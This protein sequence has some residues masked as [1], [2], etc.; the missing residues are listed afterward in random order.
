MIAAQSQRA[1]IGVARA[2]LLAA[3][4]GAAGAGAQTLAAPATG[5]TLLD[6]VR[7][8][9]KRNPNTLVQEQAVVASR[10]QLLQA[11]GQFDPVTS[12]I[13]SHGRDLRTLRRD[14]V[15][16]LQLAGILNVQQQNITATTYRVGVDRTLQNGVSIGTGVSVTGIDDTSQRLAGIPNQ[17]SGRV[18]FSLN[19]PLLR[20]SGAETV[21]AQVA[22]TDAEL[23]ASQFDLVFVNSLTVLNT[24]FAYWDAYA[25]RRL[26]DIALAA[27]KRGSVLIEEMRKL[28]EADQLAAAEIDLVAA[29]LSE[30]TGARVAAEQALVDARRVLARQ[31]GLSVA[32]MTALPM[33]SDPLP[34]YD[35]GRIDAVERSEMLVQ[36]AIAKRAD[37][38]ASRRR[39]LAAKYRVTAAR[40]NLK[41][42]LDFS[43]NLSYAGVAEGGTLTPLDRA[44]YTGLAGPSFLST[45]SLQWP[46]NNSSAR[47]NLLSQSGAHDSSIIVMRDLEAAI[48]SNVVTAAAALKRSGE[49]VVHGAEAVRRYSTTLQNELIKRRLGTATLLDV[50]TVEDRLTGAL[51][52]EVQLQQNYGNAIALLRF[53]V[54]TLVRQQGESFDIRIADLTVPDF[55][56]GE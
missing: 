3:A 50:I 45:L 8:A 44:L 51:Q 34:A 52:N 32:E 1:C 11:Q 37:L 46:F 31:L 33:P 35:G 24:A 41:P 56:P 22:A 20:N 27:E 14:E 53:A 23:T 30:K 40:N 47:G 49:Q 39:E 19:V 13:A 21:G 55:S 2:A 25:K 16:A 29:S 18:S 5:L 38:E 43:V 42:Q 48:A 4:L 9:L 28:I 7:T 54:G 17:A 26:L 12:A 10:G 15:T 36:T 6:A